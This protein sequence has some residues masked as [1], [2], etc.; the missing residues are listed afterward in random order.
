MA[1]AIRIE[2][3]SR[4]ATYCRSEYG[5]YEYGKYDR[6]SVMRGRQRRTFL[7]SFQT[8]EEAQAAYPNA[9]LH[10]ESGYRDINA[11]TAHLPGEG[12]Y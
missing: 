10:V 6:N 11:E 4:G 9:K 8:L 2:F 5:V 7:D 3:P 12:S 1:D